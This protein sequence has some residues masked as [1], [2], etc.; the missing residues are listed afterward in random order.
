M[1]DAFL[2][3]LGVY[4]IWGTVV[5]LCDNYMTLSRFLVVYPKTSKRFKIFVHAYIWILMIFTYLPYQTIL[6]CFI[7]T[8]NDD[9]VNAEDI[10]SGVVFIAAYLSYNVF[11]SYMFWMALNRKSTVTT[12]SKS[13]TLLAYKNLAHTFIR[14]VEPLSIYCIYYY[15][16]YFF[17]LVR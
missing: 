17:D 5:Q 14:C 8:N 3:T 16:M 12:S 1:S 13:M 15:Q 9:L 10:T 4:G 6:P 7:D 11:F 2:I